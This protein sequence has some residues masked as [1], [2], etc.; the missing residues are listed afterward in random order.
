MAPPPHADGGAQQIPAWVSQGSSRKERDKGGRRWVF[1]TIGVVVALAIIGTAGFFVLRRPAA[2]EA[3]TAAVVTPAQSSAT[4]T[5]TVIMPNSSGEK[6]LLAGSISIARPVGWTI[7]PTLSNPGKGTV[8]FA[9]DRGGSW[10]YINVEGDTGTKVGATRCSIITKYWKQDP[11]KVG[12][13]GTVT[14]DQEAMTVRSDPK[15]SVGTCALTGTVGAGTMAVMRQYS[16]QIAYRTA[17]GVGV[18]VRTEVNHGETLTPGELKFFR[19]QA[20]TALLGS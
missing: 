12:L 18:S 20:T 8:R 10:V 2:T 4:P 1:I 3:S 15:L 6:V 14:I 9:A 11:T 5:P 19:E 7:D 13:T 16:W 17:D